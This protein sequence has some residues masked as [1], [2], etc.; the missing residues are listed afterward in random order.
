MSGPE[1]SDRP[2]A[3]NDDAMMPE[4]VVAY[5]SLL[6]FVAP[7]LDRPTLFGTTVALHICHAIL[8]R[9]FAANAGYSRNAW[10]ILGLIGGVWAVAV[11]ILLPPRAG[12]VSGT[13][14]LR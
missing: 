3:V 5:L 6:A 8:C 11:L 12:V 2:P 13:E 1:Y 7:G 4:T 10:T 14:R 9:I